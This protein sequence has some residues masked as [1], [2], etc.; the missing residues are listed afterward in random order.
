MRRRWRDLNGDILEWDS[1]HGTVER[2]NSQG[3]HLGE[4][5]AVSGSRISPANPN[6]TVAP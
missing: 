4:Y 1:L 3:R 5:D 2:Y 6:Y